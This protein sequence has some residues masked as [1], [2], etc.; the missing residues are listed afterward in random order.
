MGT[1]TYTAFVERFQIKKKRLKN[2]PLYEERRSQILTKDQEQ[3]NSIDF[4]SVLTVKRNKE[5]T[6]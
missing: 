6:K 1:C 2:P 3:S 5:K 4:I